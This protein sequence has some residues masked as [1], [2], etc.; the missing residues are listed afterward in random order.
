MGMN[1][2]LLG[3]VRELNRQLANRDE[4]VGELTAAQEIAKLEA[5]QH[6]ALVM[7]L[8]QRIS[9]FESQH[10]GLEIT[11]GRAQQQLASL[12]H[13]YDD[14]Q[15]LILQLKAQIRYQHSCLMKLMFYLFRMFSCVYDV[16]ISF[17]MYNSAWPS[18]HGW[19][20]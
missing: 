3:K 10:S 14:A 5:E 8:R 1:R 19:V 6:S 17:G 16:I 2:S 13:E 9:D 12:Q 11:A 20:Q 18:L 4:Q 7:S 15:Q